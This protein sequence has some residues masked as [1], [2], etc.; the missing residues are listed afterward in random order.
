MAKNQAVPGMLVGGVNSS[1]EDPTVKARLKDAPVN[2]RYLDHKES[3]STNEI[4]IYW[5][6]P[7]IYLL[8]LT[9]EK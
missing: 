7:F 6:S 9:E 8:A 3:Y 2:K 5:N 4:T 1:L